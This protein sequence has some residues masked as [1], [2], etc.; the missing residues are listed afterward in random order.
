MLRAQRLGQLFPQGLGQ[1]SQVKADARGA[2]G[3]GLRV[4]SAA[5][6]VEPKALAV[7]E[8]QRAEITW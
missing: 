7:A 2:R 6:T 3:V 4:V 5:V 1:H 8:L